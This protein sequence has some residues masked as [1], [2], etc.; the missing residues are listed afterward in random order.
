M[1]GKID[2]FVAEADDGGSGVHD[3]VLR[4]PHRGCLKYVIP[5]T[6]EVSPGKNLPSF[7]TSSHV[8][9]EQRKSVTHVTHGT[10]LCFKRSVER[11]E[12]E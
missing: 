2:A 12:T 6:Q 8:H 9:K 4:T 10:G 5:S 11:T 1:E 3:E 7:L